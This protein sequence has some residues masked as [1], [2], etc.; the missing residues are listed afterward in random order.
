MPERV[1][2]RPNQCIPPEPSIRRKHNG[3]PLGGDRVMRV[4]MYLYGV[5][6]GDLAAAMPVLPN[7][8]VK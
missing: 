2:S 3:E 7:L 6:I 1:T 5:A 4:A 8:H